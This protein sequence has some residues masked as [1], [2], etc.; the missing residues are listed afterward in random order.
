MSGIDLTVDIMINTIIGEE[1]ITNTATE[2]QI[3]L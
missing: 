3:Q 1:E 2:L